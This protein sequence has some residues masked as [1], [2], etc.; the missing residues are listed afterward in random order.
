MQD[1]ERF[2][3]RKVGAVICG[4]N[5]DVRLL[6]WVLTRGLVRDGRMV[7]LRIGIVDRPGVLAK[8]AHLIGETG[9]NI[10]EVYHQRLFYD[11][12]AKQAD[13]DAVIETRNAAHVREI[14]AA[15]EAGGFPTRVLSARSDE[16]LVQGAPI[17]QA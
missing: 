16:G 4:G 17:T 14:V 12:P 10:I 5:I 7:R 11:V 13:V 2:T 15:L 8:V 3:G 9:G 1:K 6:S